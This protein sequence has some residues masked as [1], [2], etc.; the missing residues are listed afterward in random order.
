MHHISHKMQF[1]HFSTLKRMHIKRKGIYLVEY[2]S[3][4]FIGRETL[5]IYEL[6]CV[7][8]KIF[9]E[10]EREREPFLQFFSYIISL[11]YAYI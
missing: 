8:I 5:D 1:A 6:I 2:L 7:S 11:R 9:S 4:R 10:R 3:W